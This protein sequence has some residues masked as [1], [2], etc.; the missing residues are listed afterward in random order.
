MTPA[1]IIP[2]EGNAQ[3]APPGE[4][5]PNPLLI[6]VTDASGT[7][8]PGVTVTWA[9]VSGGGS[10]TPVTSTTGPEGLAS[11]RWTLGATPGEQAITASVAGVGS[12]R[13]TAMAAAAPALPLTAGYS[14]ACAIAPSGTTY[15][16]GSNAH[17]ELGVPTNECGGGSDACRSTP[18]AVSGG[19]RFRAV[20]NGQGW[21]CALTSSGSPHCWGDNIYGALGN[22]T[23]TSSKAPGPVSGGL[24][25]A[26]IT[27]GG[28]QS[29]GLTSDGAAFCWGNNTSG[30]LGDGTTIRR[31]TPIR[32]NTSHTFRSLSAGNSHTCGVTP[33]N[34]LF[35]WGANSYAQL[36]DGS[37]T[38]RSTPTAVAGG[39]Q[40][41]SVSA[42]NDH[43]CALTTDGT[44]YCWG[45][46][47]F[48]QL[49]S[50]ENMQTCSGWYG[51]ARCR[52]TPTPIASTSSFSVISSGLRHSCAIT[53]AGTS[54]CWG[55]NSTGSLGNTS[56]DQ[57]VYG[58]E[59]LACSMTPV[60]VQGGHRFAAV[61]AGQLYTCGATSAGAVF[62]WGWNH[63]GQLGNGT[64]MDASVPTRTMIP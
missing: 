29:C 57:C 53:V 12:T 38:D 56:Q 27:A 64:R 62:C 31:T 46:N 10:A 6:K 28:S 41:A 35:C 51:V 17:G 63:L 9:V 37:T 54:F 42:G 14:H 7:G 19:E 48:G 13:F 23:T 58:P 16:W 24:T 11:T 18:V 2:M 39:L 32:V 45:G 52:T 15:C 34:T 20:S 21:S 49:G 33:A 5:L 43:T 40:V 26:T 47:T 55:E 8:M 60:Q 50:R 25:L 44:V 61:A 4:D 59:T 36:G 1:A 3:T 22:G 30:Q